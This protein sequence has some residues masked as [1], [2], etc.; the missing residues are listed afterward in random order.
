VL[1]LSAFTKKQER[2]AYVLKFLAKEVA[3]KT[4]SGVGGVKREHVHY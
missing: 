4:F 1:I 2:A 3:E